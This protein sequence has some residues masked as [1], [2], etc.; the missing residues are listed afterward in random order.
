MPRCMRRW[1]QFTADR[2]VWTI[3]GRVRTWATDFGRPLILLPVRSIAKEMHET[4]ALRSLVFGIVLVVLPRR[5][6]WSVK[7]RCD[8]CVALSGVPV[9]CYHTHQYS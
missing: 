2:G 1:L 8:T 3:Y 4:S 9:I 6:P 5:W 7:K